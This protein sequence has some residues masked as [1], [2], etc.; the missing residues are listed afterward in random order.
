D[1]DGDGID[2]CS[3]DCDDADSDTYP[4]AAENESNSVLCMRDRDDD[5][6]GDAAAGGDISPGTD[7]DDS[8]ADLSPADG[9]GDGV[10]TCGGDCDDRDPTRSPDEQEIPGDGSDSDCDGDDGGFEVEASG[11]GGPGY[12]IEDNATIR[13][14]AMVS[15]CA[16]VWDI[17][18][19]VDITHTYV[20]DLYITLYSPA[21]RS[22]LLHDRDGGTQEDL[23]GVYEV[24]NVGSLT[25]A[26]DLAA[27]IGAGGTGT[28]TLEVSD[29]VSFDDGQLNSWFL[30]LTCT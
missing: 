6:Y 19:G 27:L 14:Q 23:S 15:T 10:S 7:C 25:S 24:G 30:V 16:T 26:E 29:A 4:G 22:V 3:G 9:D 5:G 20:G 13:S 1:D 8:D 18:V 2:T 11:A 12:D 28:W 21:G 17:S